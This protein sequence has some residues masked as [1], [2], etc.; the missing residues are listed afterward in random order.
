MAVPGAPFGDLP[1]VLAH[2]EGALPDRFD[3]AKFARLCLPSPSRHA[4]LGRTVL[5]AVDP[6][7]QFRYKPDRAHGCTVFNHGGLWLPGCAS[8]ARGLGAVLR[9][10]RRVPLPRGSGGSGGGLQVMTKSRLLKVSP[11]PRLAI[12]T[13]PAPV[14]PLAS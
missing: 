13:G 12:C 9:G 6:F 10:G 11:L 7:G 5:P 14:L 1:E 4:T 3:V 8:A 2:L